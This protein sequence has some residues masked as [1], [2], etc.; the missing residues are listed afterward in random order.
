[1]LPPICFSDVASRLQ[2]RMIGQ[3]RVL[4]LMM[5]CMVL[6]FAIAGVQVDDVFFI[7]PSVAIF[8]LL[9]FVWLQYVFVLRDMV[10]LRARRMV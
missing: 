8:L 1:M 4:L 3:Y 7:K 6:G 2:V 10:R 9:V 5:G